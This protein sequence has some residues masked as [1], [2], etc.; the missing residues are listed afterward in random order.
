MENQFV[1]QALAVKKSYH[2]NK[3][4]VPVLRGVDLNISSGVVTALV[5]RTGSGKST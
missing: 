1:L 3:I 2:K 5:G 4:E